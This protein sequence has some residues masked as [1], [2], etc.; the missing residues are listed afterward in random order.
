[1]EREIPATVA[2]SSTLSVGLS[3]GS[4][5]ITGE[6]SGTGGHHKYYLYHRTHAVVL[7]A[8]LV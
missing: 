7:H 2:N 5:V 1:V 6:T 8:F 3:L 4:S